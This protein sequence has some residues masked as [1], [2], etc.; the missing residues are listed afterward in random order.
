MK[1]KLLTLVCVLATILLAACGLKKVDAGDYLKTSFSGLDSKGSLV[2]NIDTQEIVKAFLADNPKADAKTENELKVALTELQVTPSKDSG[3]S[4][5]EEIT[6]T[7]KSTKKLEKYITIPSEKKVK[8]SGLRTAK[9]L[10]AEDLAK[11]TSLEVEGFNKK[12][13]A[14]VHVTDN[15]L[16]F[17]RFKVVNNGQLENGKD[18][19]IQ[20]N[21]NYT[22]LLEDK[23]YVLEGDG[24]FTLPVKGLKTLA[25]KL[26]EVK[27][28]DEIIAKLKEEINK[29][30]SGNDKITFD[31]TYY[32][33]LANNVNNS[34][35]YGD[36]IVSGNGNLVMT[37]QVESSFGFKNVYAVGFTNLV[38]NE[39]GKM[40]MK[41]AKVTSTMYADF[42]TATQ[43][44]EAIGYT[45]VK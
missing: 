6:F 16:D 35:T 3:L 32:R 28:K 42:S 2:Y 25:D 18:A 12:G 20:L 11:A 17:L 7:F 23:G 15:S 36:D 27:N 14:E 19:Q 8:V 9:K 38:T 24:S 13:K 37:I 4:N 40:E 34:N 29:K 41:D 1:K 39:D 10:T 26:D 45:E 30:F 21:G 44:L 22:N 31:K 5:D 43:K 33:G